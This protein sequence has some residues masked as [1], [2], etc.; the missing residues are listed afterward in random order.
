MRVLS[1]VDQRGNILEGGTDYGAGVV[2]V[3]LVVVVEE[4]ARDEAAQSVE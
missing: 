3:E 2:L 4:L 1:R